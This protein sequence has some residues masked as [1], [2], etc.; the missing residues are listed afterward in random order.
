[1]FDLHERLLLLAHSL[2]GVQTELEGAT[3]RFYQGIP[4][5]PGRLFL[6]VIEADHMVYGLLPHPQCHF[7]ASVVFPHP[8]YPGWVRVA[9]SGEEEEA[10]LWQS[11]LY[12][13]QIITETLPFGPSVIAT[14][15]YQNVL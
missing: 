7:R 5:L 1:M 15:S 2:E 10:L 9:Q 8:A 4:T 6:E 14:N 11:I 12:S 13:Y 3:E